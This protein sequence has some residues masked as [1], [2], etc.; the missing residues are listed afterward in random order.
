MIAR[1]VAATFALMRQ[2]WEQKRDHWPCGVSGESWKARP[3]CGLRQTRW[4]PFLG[5]PRADF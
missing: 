4:R 1:L 5:M 3:Q 2:S